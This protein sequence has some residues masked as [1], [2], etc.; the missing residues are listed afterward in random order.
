MSNIEEK[1]NEISV[2]ADEL[3]NAEYSLQD[4]TNN[5]TDVQNNINDLSTDALNLIHDERLE[6]IDLE[7][8]KMADDQLRGLVR[9]I[10]DERLGV[11]ITFEDKKEKTA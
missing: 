11:E 7:L 9:K 6:R 8:N 4:A 2:K 3:S 10:C 5:V 1:L